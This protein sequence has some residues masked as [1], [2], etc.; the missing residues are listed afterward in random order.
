MIKVQILDEESEHKE[1]AWERTLVH[2]GQ[3]FDEARM[4]FFEHI[5]LRNDLIPVVDRQGKIFYFLFWEANQVDSLCYVKDFWNYDITNAL[6]DYELL[7]RGE[8]YLFFMLEEYTFQIANIIQ[9]KY[10]SKHIF[11][12]DV[13]A[14]LFFEETS[15]LHI[16][17]SLADLYNN[18][19][20]YIS[21]TILTIDSKKEFLHNNMRFI[22]KRYRSLSVMT[23]LFWRCDV[24]SYGPKNPDKT[25]Y[26]I[27]DS[28]GC[29]GLGD[30][31]K[32]ALTKV[33]MIHEKP[34]NV[35]P[36]I[37]FSV[38]GDLNQFTE[39]NG[40]NAWTL[41]FK[42]I[43]DVPL[44]E[45]YESKNVIISSHEGWDWFNPYL[46]EK[47]CFM[48]WKHMFQKYLRIKDEV[49]EYIEELFDKT[50]QNKDM[51]ILGVVGRGTDCCSTRGGMPEP[52]ETSLFL[53]EVKKA[54]KRW[55]CASIFLATEDQKVYE[56][57]M[58][59]DLHN[60]IQVV[61]QYRI[62]YSKKENNNLLLSEIKIR[63]H[64]NGYWDSLNYLGI[65]YILSKC[66]SLISTCSCGAVNCAM[67][68]KGDRY[69]HI[70][71][72]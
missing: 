40:E 51:K 10:P 50:I 31:L 19:K 52:L 54:M 43:C 65:L 68:L 27:K 56:T 21:K 61:D 62:D 25:F 38:K 2:S 42:Q 26:V 67:A 7:D 55:N 59:S 64:K 29:S 9:K 63:E 14:R 66:D 17:S 33:A 30:M 53:E 15:Y 47:Q 24:I 5:H 3:V 28:L 71:I 23:S 39:G 57:F 70:K 18:Y 41:Y 11:F 20:E 45:V 22:I 48:D 46:Y 72:F 35:I 60:K 69:C 6:I 32:R 36:V 34:G 49:R 16:I 44:E 4:I 37:D 12:M 58:D 8:V 1:I 13:N